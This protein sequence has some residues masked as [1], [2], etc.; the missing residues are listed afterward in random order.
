MTLPMGMTFDQLLTGKVRRIFK[1]F[2]RNRMECESL[3]VGTFSELKY[4]VAFQTESQ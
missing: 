2:P 3:R 4:L 1:K